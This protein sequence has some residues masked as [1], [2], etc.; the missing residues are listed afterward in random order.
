VNEARLCVHCRRRPVA[1]TWQP[2]CSERCRLFDLAAWADGSY[3]IPGPLV[4][5]EHLAPAPDEER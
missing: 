3:R 1:A 2:F 4:D 5:P